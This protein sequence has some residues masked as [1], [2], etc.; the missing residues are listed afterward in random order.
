[1]E[2][3][4]EITQ[5]ISSLKIPMLKTRDYDLWSMRMEQYLTHTDYALWEVFING[6]SLVP[7]PPAVGTVVPPKT[8]AQKLDRKNE[9]KAK[10]TL[11][12]AILD[13]HL[14]KFHSIKDAKF[15][16]LISQLELNGEVI[17]QEDANMKLLRS[18][19]LS[20]N[21]ISLIMRNK[22]DIETLSMDDLYNNLK[23][24]EAEIK[25]QSSS[26]FN[27]HNVSFLSSKN[28]SNINETVTTAHDILVA[29]SNKQ[30]SAPSYADDVMFS[31]FAS[32]SNTPQLDNEDLEQIHTDD[33]EEMDLKWKVAM[34]TIRVKKFMKRT[35]R[36]IN[37]NGKEPFGFNK[38]KVECYNCH[39]IRHFARECGA[40][41]NQGNRSADNERR[42]IPV[43]TPASALVLEETMKEKDDL[44]EKVTKFKESSK[45]LT[46]PI[47]SQM[48]ANDK[49]G[50]GY[51]SQL[52]ENKMPK[53]EI[54]ETASDSSVSKID[55]DNNK[56]KIGLDDFVFNF[57]IS[58]TRSSVNENESIA[59][60]SSEEIRDEPKTVRS[61]ALVI[62]DWESDFED[63]C[64]DKTSIEQEIPSNGNSVKSVES[65]KNVSLKITQIILMK[66][67]EKDKILGSIG[68]GKNVTT[69]GPKASVNAA[70]GK[71]EN[72][73]KSSACWIWRPKRNLINH[74]SKDNGSYTL[75]RFNYVD[76]NDRLK[77]ARAWALTGNKSV[78]TEYQKIDGG[79]VAFGGSPKG[80]KITGKGKIRTGKLDF[81]DV[82]FVK[83]LKFNLLSVSQM[84]DKKNSVLFTETE[85]LVLSPDFKLLDESQVL[86]KVPRQNDMHS[87]DLK[88]VVLSG[89]LTCLFVKATIDESSSWHR[90]LGHINFKTLNKLVRGNLVIGSGPEWLFDIDSLTKSMNYKP[91]STGNQSNGDADV[92]PG[93]VNAGDQPG[94]VNASDIQGDVDE[95]LRNDDVCQGNKIRID[96]STYAVNAA[97]TSINTANNIIVAGSLNINTADSSHTN[98]PTL[99]ATGIF[100]GA[101]DNRDLGAEADTNNLDS[102]IVVNPIP[103]TRVHKDNLKEQ[104]IGD[105]NLNTQTRR[106]INFSKKLL[107][108]ASLTGREGQIIKIFRTACLF[109]SCPKWNPRRDIGSKWVFRNKL[110]ERGIVI[111][112]KARLV[113]QGYKQEEGIDYDEVFAP[114][115]RI[116]AIRLFMAYASFKDFIVYQMD[117]NSAFLYGTIEEEVYVC[118]PPGFKDPDFPDKVYEVKKALYGLHQA[119]RAWYETLSTYLLNNGF[120]RGQ[121]DK[122]LFI[123]RNKD[124]IL[125]VQVYVDDIIF[126]STKKEMCDAFE[127]LM[128]EKFQMSLM[129]ELTFFLGLQVKQKRDGIFISQDK[130]VAKIL[131]KFG[132]FEVKTTSTLMETSKPLLKDE[133]GQEVDVHIYRS[134]IGSLMYLTSSRPVIMFAVCACG[135][136]QVSPKV[137]H[138]Q[139]VKR[140]FRYLKGQPKLGNLQL[141]DVNYLVVDLYPGSVKSRQ[142][143]QTTQLRL[144]MLLLQVIVDSAASWKLMLPSIK[145]QMLITVNAA[146]DMGD[147]PI[148][149]YQTPI[150]D[151]PS[152]SQP[153]KPQN[154]R[155]K[156]RKE[157]K[158]SHGESADVDHVPTPSS[159]LLPSGEDS[160]ILNELIVFC[161]SLQEQVLDL[162]EAK[163]AQAKEI[164]ALK[165]KVSKLNKWRKSRS[166]GIKRL[167][168]FGSVRRVKH[169]IEKYGL[170]AQEDASKQER[171][172]KEID[173]NAEIALDDETQGRINNDEIEMRKV[174]DFVAMDSEAQKSSAKE[175]QERSTKRTAKHLEFDISKKQKV[176]ENV[177]PVV[178]DSEK[179]R[180]CIEILPDDGDEVLI[181]ATPISSRSPTIIDYKIHKERKKTYF[182][183]IRADDNSQ[184]Y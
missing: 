75:K 87:F 45:N 112:N 26:G 179:L 108:S 57:E 126:R 132:F 139:A 149:T 142:W 67:L 102:S 84:C 96:S 165:A 59:S 148:E 154:P 39:K 93:D 104:I 119:P 177:E 70:E 23:V 56:K 50:L 99:E 5:N 43:E 100:D 175:A 170:G 166:G 141:V 183:I 106:M 135:R 161:T 94:D 15:Q 111:R 13:E 80:G 156:Q 42:V 52:S 81:E 82:Y 174:N 6:D 163:D 117:V 169:H 48:S 18:L 150:V 129:G 19:P 66:T 68:M 176:D 160:S 120:K 1:M 54:F 122:T 107:W 127:I 103:T 89:D 90:R 171:M 88:N 146:Q 180:K 178:D 53:C 29:G 20:W 168:K 115:A 79:F 69:V 152:T 58:E 21:N 73:V 22:L 181:E 14:L 10:N 25:G 12:L 157:A 105:P 78:L 137:S 91:V 92:K 130:Y 116:E 2:T 72:A 3:Q 35:G 27:S 114:V 134:M 46:K 155:R 97:S 182:K 41:R 44:K 61:S 34:I 144:S 172:I 85:C 86:L 110:D 113:A 153:Q 184:V 38:T 143:L 28:T 101:F 11:L 109:V 36:N 8:E 98:M 74:T 138:L 30:P 33:L 123:K 7:E 40:L 133:D 47:N 24:Y 60:K 9:L 51:D 62:K 49:A 145:L 77:S 128:H 55:E 140:I 159:D 95:I 162:Q 32:Q 71:K 63:E 65:N 121:I 118:Q 173:Q 131:E 17:S 136:H 76:P 158:T 147:I 64:E 151:Q 16:K 124:D 37:F 167:K 83:E 164:V 125:L 4:L 31:F